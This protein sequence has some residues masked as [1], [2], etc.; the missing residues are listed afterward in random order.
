MTKKPDEKILPGVK[1]GQLRERDLSGLQ[2]LILQHGV[3]F[4]GAV[5][6]Y[7]VPPGDARSLTL[8]GSEWFQQGKAASWNEALTLAHKVYWQMY[9]RGRGASQ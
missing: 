4:D 8:A 7:I 3:T 9:E 2:A 6:R 5:Q 1:P